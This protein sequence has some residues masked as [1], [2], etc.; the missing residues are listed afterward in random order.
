VT[1]NHSRFIICISGQGLDDDDEDIDDE[2]MG[3]YTAG[4]S[5]LLSRKRMVDSDESDGSD[6]YAKS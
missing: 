6:G 3:I 4:G 1:T 5:P 2:E